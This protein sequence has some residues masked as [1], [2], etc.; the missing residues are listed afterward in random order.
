MYQVQVYV[1]STT[2]PRGRRRWTDL[3]GPAFATP[4]AAW[5]CARHLEKTGRGPA[6]C[7]HVRKG[8]KRYDGIC[9]TPEDANPEALTT[10]AMAE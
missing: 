2:D 8:R 6:R 9:W 3:P 1:P 10:A 4:S 5:K 7:V